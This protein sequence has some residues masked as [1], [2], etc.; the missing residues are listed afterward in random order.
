MRPR[1]LIAEDEPYIAQS[2][3]RIVRVHG[4]ATVVTTAQAADQALR[5]G[6]DWCGLIF[7]I[8]LPD[9]SGLDLLARA[10]ALYPT[11]PALL[12]TGRLDPEL[13][14]RAFDLRASYL[15][16]PVVPERVESFVVS[17]VRGESTWSLEASI[18][19]QVRIW[20]ARY[21]LRQAEAD[22]LLRSARGESRDRIAAQRA[23]TTETVKK[24]VARLLR[25]TSDGNL[26][27]AVERLLRS[28]ARAGRPA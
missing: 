14:N 4:D 1:F 22:V 5:E 3:D 13:V 11:V 21:G 25:R 6:V 20:T 10:R 7:D 9:G 24:I 26:H 23:C 27:E 28:A 12:Q 19:A 16:K 17:S 8:G 2:L 18:Q 15:V